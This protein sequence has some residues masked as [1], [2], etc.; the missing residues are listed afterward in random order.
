LSRDSN[1]LSLADRIGRRGFMAK[2]TLAAV[3]LATAFVGVPQAA[4][5]AGAVLVGCCGLCRSSTNPCTGSCCWSWTCCS[6]SGTNM[7]VCKECYTTSGCS[8]DGCS[9]NRCSQRIVT[10]ARCA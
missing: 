3:S 8:G 7:Q 6:G 5:A 9:S 1:V 10:N 2:L 4:H